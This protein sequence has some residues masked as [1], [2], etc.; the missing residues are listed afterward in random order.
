VGGQIVVSCG[1]ATFHCGNATKSIPTNHRDL[2][3][4][5]SAYVNDGPEKFLE[6]AEQTEW[7]ELKSALF[8]NGHEALSDFV[9]YD[10]DAEEDK[11][12]TENRLDEAYQQM[13]PEDFAGYYRQYVV[14]GLAR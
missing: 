2:R 9:G 13:P 6:V 3:K 12:V 8:E 10:F 5:V 11:D 4:W 7:E 14:L 1:F